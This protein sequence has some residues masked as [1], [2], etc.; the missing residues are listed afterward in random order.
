MDAL[1]RRRRWSGS[2]G[3]FMEEGCAGGTMEKT[4]GSLERQECA[5]VPL[6]CCV[7]GLCHDVTVYSI[8][9]TAVVAV[10]VAVA[11]VF[12]VVVTFEGHGCRGYVTA[13]PA[14]IFTIS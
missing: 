12:V 13:I 10:I 8:P 2:G 7:S 6:R 14:T 9:A 11:V 4:D 3:G 5:R 1:L